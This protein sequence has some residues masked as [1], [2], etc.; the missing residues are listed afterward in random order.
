M[1]NLFRTF[2]NLINTTR[3]DVK[4]VTN[5]DQCFDLVTGW[6]KMLGLPDTIFNGILYAK[7]LYLAPTQVMRDN[8]NFI[9]NTPTAIPQVGDIVV[10]N[11]LVG[12][13]SVSNGIGNLTTFQSFD[14]NYPTG[15][16]CKL[17][18]HNYDN[19]R[20]LG[21]IRYKKSLPA[22]GD[23]T[24]LLQKIGDL[25]AT[26]IRLKTEITNKDK[27]IIERDKTISTLTTK[28]GQ[29]KTLAII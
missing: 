11:G 24:A 17:I 16:E 13:T 23:I 27:S 10:F 6:A 14:Q 8:F 28:L 15:S 7:N 22:K 12:H 9:E 1:D 19:P 3:W 26:E 29:I 20:V 18:I 2:F 5:R 25:Q 4:D 21:W